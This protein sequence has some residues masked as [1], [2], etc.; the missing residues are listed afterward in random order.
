MRN[1]VKCSNC[2]FFD[3]RT[4]RAICRCNAPLR[5][6]EGYINFP[7]V[8]SDDWCGKF[9]ATEKAS[10][11]LVRR[12]P[13][14]SSLTCSYCN[15]FMTGYCPYCGDVVEASRPFVRAIKVIEEKI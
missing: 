15:C 7:R 2:K 13:L 1:D 9:Q 12:D 8:E 6:S 5:G 14:P 10:F 4:T 3:C 11:K